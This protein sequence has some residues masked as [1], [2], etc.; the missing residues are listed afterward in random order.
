MSFHPTRTGVP[1][2]PPI[3][4]QSPLGGVNNQLGPRFQ[5]GNTPGINKGVPTSFGNPAG[6]TPP[7]NPL[8]GGPGGAQLG[9][10]NNQFPQGGFISPPP[11]VGQPQI[12]MSGLPPTGQPQ[13]HPRDPRIVDGE[14][15]PQGPPTQPQ[16]QPLQQP[17]QPQQAFGLSGSEQALQAGLGAGVSALGQGSQEALSTLL[18]GNNLAQQQFGSGQQLLQGAGQQAQGQIQQGLGGLLG[19]AQ[20]GL[21]QIQ[22]GQ[23]AAQQQI[24][25]AQN[26]L[27]GGAQAGVGQIQQGLGGAL[28]QLGQGQA[29]LGGG[30][31]ASAQQANVNTGQPLFQQAAQGVG[32][33]SGAGL[34]AQGLQSALSGAQGQ[35]AF[36]QALLNSPIQQFL[37][38]QGEQS[39]INQAAATGG[40]G[41]GAIQQELTRFG[42]GLA[43]TQLQQQ[44]QNLQS[45]SGQ[46][47]Q[48][49]GQQGQFLSQAGQQQG[50]LAGQNAALGTQANIASAANR[51]GAAQGQANL[52]GQGAQAFQQAGLQGANILG[53]ATGQS[54]Q[55][56]GQGAG[57]ASQAGQAGANVLGQAAGQGASLLGQ[58][59]GL[60]AQLGA[61]GAGLFGQG[62]GISAALAGQGAG[63]QAGT[64]QN[65]ANLFSGTGQQLSQGRLQA[66]RDIAGQIGSTTSALSGLANQQGSGLSDIIGA[67]GSNLANL[68]SGFGQTSAEQREGLARLLANLSV[69]QGTQEAG[70]TQQA[71]NAIA[72]AN[73][74]ATQGQQELAGTVV[75]SL[76]GGFSDE[77]L[78]ENIT[79]I[80]NL[81][82]VNFYNWS[83]NDKMPIK[84]LIGKESQGVIAQE[85][86]LIH[87]ELVIEDDSGFK[88]VNYIGLGEKL[89]H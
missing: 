25:G 49:A 84:E 11:Q 30:F 39:R 7:F 3:F 58:G 19:G 57:L 68:L 38:E 14:V 32:A 54:A 52:F 44:I 1:Q 51:L 86:E 63:I 71:G 76:V 21:S 42:Q 56:A 80:G 72:N 16:V 61:Q 62:A 89:W 79:P 31:G 23:Q 22:Q 5:A 40:L 77:R 37:R 69:G 36:D 74:A 83:W 20:G 81:D 41:G 29:A 88:K 12:T 45:L 46:G 50:Q 34:Q 48:A 4:G 10:V 75:G 66:G 18:L 65:V 53:Q 8:G 35:E 13:I 43:G 47:L 78:K 27:L 64:G 70:L 17:P 28:S 82:G 87:P 67:G 73:L 55:L 6:Q 33:F 60:S 9:G 15:F 24:G 85:L 26:L 2:R 59:A